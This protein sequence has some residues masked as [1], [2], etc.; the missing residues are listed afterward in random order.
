E[1]RHIAER[2]RCSAI[3]VG[4][5]EFGHHLAA[6]VSGLGV[7]E[8]SLKTVAHLNAVLVVLDG[9]ENQNASV[10]LLLADLPVVKELVRE[11]FNGSAV[12]RVNR[13]YEDL[14]FGLVMYL[15]AECFHT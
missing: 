11:L 7:V 14:C 1:F 4:G 8:N 13:N 10:G 15:A 6:D 12:K 3:V 9:K 2:C 5:F